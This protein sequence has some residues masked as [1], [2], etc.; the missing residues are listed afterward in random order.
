MLK[1]EPDR[2]HIKKQNSGP[3]TERIGGKAV[4]RGANAW[5]CLRK[6]TKKHQD[7]KGEGEEI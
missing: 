3:A 1:K 7:I 6:R 4:L 5:Y 2:R